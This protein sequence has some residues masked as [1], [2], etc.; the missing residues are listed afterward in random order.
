MK[1]PNYG[2]GLPFLYLDAFSF[3]YT[4]EFIEKNFE[5]WSISLFFTFCPTP[6]TPGVLKFT[7]YVPL[8]LK[9]LQTR[10]RS[11]GYQE[12]FVTGRKRIAMNTRSPEFTQVN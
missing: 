9:M 1:F 8:I 4:H 3:S 2:R 12:V 10:N 5:K 6:K 7:I 11:S